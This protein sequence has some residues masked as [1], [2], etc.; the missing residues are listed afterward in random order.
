MFS[1]VV[2]AVLFTM[3]VGAAL[4]ILE[5]NLYDSVPAVEGVMVPVQVNVTLSPMT[6][7]TGAWV[8]PV[9][10]MTGVPGGADAGG[11]EAGGLSSSLHPQVLL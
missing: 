1:S 10:A 4:L 7:A 9:H 6:G 3:A 2:V 8:N 5:R 11:S